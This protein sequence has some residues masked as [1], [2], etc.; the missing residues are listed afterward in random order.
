MPQTTDHPVVARLRAAGAV[1]VG[2]TRAPELCLYAATDGPGTVTRNPWDTARS[3]AGS[4]GG[5]AAAV[6]SG[7]VPLAHGN[8]GLGSLRLPAAACGL[9]TLKPGRG[10]VPAGIGFDDWSGMAVNGALATTVADVALAHAV[11]AGEEPGR[12]ADPARPLRIALSTKSPVPGVTADGPARAAGDERAALLT[13][14]GHT[15]VRRD[16]P[17]TMG[18]AAGALARWM[19]GAEDDA[20]H[21][22][23]DRTA[24]QPRSRAH[25][26][27]GRL[28]RR[29]GLVRPRT[30]ERFR[31]RMVAWFGDVDLLLSPV[32]TGPPLPARPWHERSF[33]A[34]IT[35]N[36]R[37]APWTAAWNLAGLPALVLPAGMRPEGLPLA[38]QFVGPPGAEGRLLLLAGELERQQPWRRYAPVFD[39]I[40][41]PVPAPV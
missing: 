32:T 18:A 27:V 36:A 4:S 28:V 21:L 34:N 35:A 13:A 41:P 8:D 3:S 31:D 9:V 26:R 6:A 24:L 33:L 5:S 25:A 19:A 22:G 38:V 23:I 20:Q 29:A 17:I 10:V 14:A 2:I 15:V 39:P 40:A 16:P 30:A 7:S 1:V 37:W 12:P 11:M